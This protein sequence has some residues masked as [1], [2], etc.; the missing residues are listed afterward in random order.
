MV[1]CINCGYLIEERLRTIGL[2]SDVR[3][4]DNIKCYRKVKFFLRDGTLPGLID[5]KKIERIINVPK[6][7]KLYNDKIPGLTPE[8]LLEHELYKQP[9]MILD[10][11]ALRQSTI[12]LWISGIAI[13]V[14]IIGSVIIPSCQK[15]PPPG[16]SK[17][18]NGTIR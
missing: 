4:P 1:K 2:F 7:C 16:T 17:I 9:E 10:K 11:R 15:R 5:S 3:P 13:L 18:Y 8:R 14:S 12:S 6:K